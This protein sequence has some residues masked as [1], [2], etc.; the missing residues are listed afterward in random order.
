MLFDGQVSY[1]TPVI[2]LSGASHRRAF[3]NSSVSHQAI[4]RIRY[5]EDLEELSSRRSDSSFR[6]NSPSPNSAAR[7]GR[8]S[9]GVG[10]N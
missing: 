1:C 2:S 7:A 4:N 5:S 10:G 9:S 6:S 3:M 8:D